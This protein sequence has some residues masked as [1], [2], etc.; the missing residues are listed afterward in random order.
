[1]QIRGIIDKT[2]VN[3]PGTRTAIWTQGCQM[4]CTGCSNTET[5]DSKE[6][7]NLKTFDIIKKIEN[8]YRMHNID[9]VTIS[10]GEPFDQ[11]EEL[12]KLLVWLKLAR[13]DLD[14][15]VYTGKE[16]SEIKNSDILNYIDILIAGPFVEKKKNLDLLWRG[17]S[18]QEIHFLNDDI[19]SR[20][21]D[22]YHMMDDQGNLI[23][24]E[25]GEEFT[26]EEDGTIQVTGFTDLCEKKL[27]D[28][29]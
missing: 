19:K 25:T 18:N 2:K 15:L 12:H 27:Q 3:G 23:E 24:Q 14:V 16:M 10:G 28:M 29:V 26:I 22:H 8:N 11:P 5:W 4:H 21:A 7:T 20:M 17:S 1:M 6:G 13:F 9:G